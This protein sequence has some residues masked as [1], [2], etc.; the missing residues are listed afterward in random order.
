[1]PDSGTII[2]GEFATNLMFNLLVFAP[3]AAIVAGGTAT[4]LVSAATAAVGGLIM[5]SLYMAWA[6]LSRSIGTTR[7]LRLH[8]ISTLL[9]KAIA[10]PLALQLMFV[11][12]LRAKPAS[13]SD[14]FIEAADIVWRGM[15]AEGFLRM[16]LPQLPA[17]MYGSY[18]ILRKFALFSYCT[19]YFMINF[20]GETH[21]K[22]VL[23]VTLLDLFSVRCRKTPRRRR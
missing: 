11:D 1:M 18:I 14:A 15:H 5:L 2:F 7:L 21:S 22:M 9:V 13:P 20:G 6:Y 17:E 19:A 4:P 16:F 10:L 3:A 12:R 23:L 8:I